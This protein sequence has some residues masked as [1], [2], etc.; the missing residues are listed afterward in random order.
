MSESPFTF[1]D[2]DA[3]DLVV[4]VSFQTLLSDEMGTQEKRKHGVPVEGHYAVV[5]HPWCTAEKCKVL[6]NKGFVHSPS[7]NLFSNKERSIR[8]WVQ[9]VKTRHGIAPQVP[10][11][12]KAKK[13]VQDI[14]RRSQRYFIEAENKSDGSLLLVKNDTD[15]LNIQIEDMIHTVEQFYRPF[16]STERERTLIFITLSERLKMVRAALKWMS[17]NSAQFPPYAVVA[18]QEF[19]PATRDL[20]S[21]TDNVR[22]LDHNR[23]AMHPASSCNSFLRPYDCCRADVSTLL[24]VRHCLADYLA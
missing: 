21:E 3:E 7:A 16:G 11:V 12:T 8:E 14:V 10:N 17:E 1:T 5:A 4:F 22:N 6:Y 9:R 23:C 13:D 18:M 24:L 2:A 15:F 20:L 19:I